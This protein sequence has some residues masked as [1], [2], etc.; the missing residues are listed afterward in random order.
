MV[1]AGKAMPQSGNSPAA[2]MILDKCIT[3][4]FRDLRPEGRGNGLLGG[5]G[6]LDERS[7]TLG[8]QAIPL[9]RIVKGY[10][11]PEV[12]LVEEITPEGVQQRPLQIVRGHGPNLL[13]ELNVRV[14]VRCA[15]VRRR[16]LAASGTEGRLRTETCP[17]CG[18]TVDLTDFPPSPQIYCGYCDSVCTTDSQAPPDESAYHICWTCGLY[19]YPK[20]L[21]SMTI[22]FVGDWHAEYHECTGC[23]KKHVG[24]ALLGNLLGL[25]GLPFALWQFLRVHLGGPRFSR[26]FSGLDKAN[27]LVRKGKFDAAIV[28]YER[29]EQRM[30][31]CAGVRFNR[32]VALR[33]A[34]RTAEGRDVLAEALNDCANYVPAAD[35]L[36]EPDTPGQEPV[37]RSS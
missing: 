31:S 23:L 30:I 37:G 13:R 4:R 14:S 16:E 27:G 33:R 6:R 29:I 12:L 11:L 34:G 2:G 25:V 19:A 18:A 32:A 20:R 35:A 24:R 8:D 22:T 21:L 10:R 9:E 15:E 1:G 26:A 3:F 36:A 17:Y 5:R 7:L 28:E